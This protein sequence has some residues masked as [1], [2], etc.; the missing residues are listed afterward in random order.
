MMMTTKL[1]KEIFKLPLGLCITYNRHLNALLGTCTY[2]LGS[3]YTYSSINRT[4]GRIALKGW[5]MVSLHTFYFDNSSLNP[6]EA[7]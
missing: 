6:T 4:L 2:L 7:K 3:K 1:I 5:S